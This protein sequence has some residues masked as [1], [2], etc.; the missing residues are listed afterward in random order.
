MFKKFSTL[1]GFPEKFIRKGTGRSIPFF[2]LCISL[3]LLIFI[4]IYRK[5][6]HFQSL[7]KMANKLFA[8]ISKDALVDSDSDLLPDSLEWITLSDPLKVDTDSDGV[9]DFVEIVSYGLASKKGGA[10]RPKNGFRV[11][12]NLEPTPKRVHCK[13]LWVHCLFY[14]PSGS[15][16]EIKGFSLFLDV[17]GIRFPLN[18]LIKRGFV[19]L[20][21]GRDL[22]GGVLVRSTFKASVPIKKFPNKFLISGLAIVGNRLL[23]S[24]SLMVKDGGSFL[25]IVRLD[26]QKLGFQ[27][28]GRLELTNPFWS[29]NRV[30]VFNLD[31]QSV[32]AAGLLCE[33]VSAK[34]QIASRFKCAPNCNKMKGL[35]FILPD[36]LGVVVGG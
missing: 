18:D 12:F 25:T 36:G 35:T 2:L 19:S 23:R 3:I 34:C 10:S 13:D 28:A 21:V 9:S 22:K 32:G 15:L 24:G 33:V 6:G 7:K 1:L 31:T 29:K 20:K 17:S 11:L 14:I 8:S 5:G 26:K 4:G 27:T 30:C 16:T